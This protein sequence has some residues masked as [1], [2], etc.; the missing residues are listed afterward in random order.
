MR[1]GSG[2]P[3]SCVANQSSNKFSPS[4]RYPLGIPRQPYKYDQFG[5]NLGEPIVRN[6]LFFF[7][8]YEGQRNSEPVTNILP[9]APSDAASQQAVR[10]LAQYTEPYQRRQDNNIYL[11]K[12]DWNIGAN[13]NLSTRY[14]RHRF[15]GVNFENTFQTHPAERGTAATTR[16]I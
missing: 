4:A 3:R 10:D 2:E 15:D 6:K 9:A 12:I 8:N 1:S 13:Q 16:T 11:V 5:A 7:F 14:N